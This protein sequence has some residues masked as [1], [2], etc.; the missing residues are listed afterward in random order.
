MGIKIVPKK[1]PAKKKP[2]TLKSKQLAQSK[3][4]AAQRRLRTNRGS[5][6]SNKRAKGG[7]LVLPWD[8]KPSK[9]SVK[10]RGRARKK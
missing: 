9:G 6:L 10:S 8:P 5:T 2:A 1:K 3:A 7:P 4:T